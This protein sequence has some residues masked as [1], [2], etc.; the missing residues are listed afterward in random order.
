MAPKPRVLCV[1]DEPQVLEG[2]TLSLRR[3]YEVVTANSGPAGLE[4][5]ARD[6]GVSV[7]VSDMRM[8]GMDGATFLGKARAMAPDATRILLT[9]HADVDGAAAAIN[10]GRIFRFLTKPCSP[11]S[12]V[13]ALDAAVEQHRLVTAE[14]VLLQQTLRGSMQMMMDVLALA[15][16]EAFGRAVRLRRYASEIVS[17]VPGA[18][19]WPVEVAA[20]L[21]E[22][23]IVSL[24]SSTVEKLYEGKPLTSEE[25][26]SVDR[27]PVVI[28]QLIAGIPRLDAVR[29]ALKYQA[30]S[31]EGSGAP[32]TAPRG[33]DIPL[34]ARV[35]RIVADFDRLERG[36]TSESVALDTMRG[37]RGRYDPELLE[38]FAS[39]LGKGTKDVDVLELPIRAVSAGM[40]FLEDVR[41]QA[42][43]LLVA[44][45]HEVTASL[46]ERVR[47]F[48]PGSV[49][50]PV[51]VSARRVARR[52]EGKDPS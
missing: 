23:G 30:V 33:K 40:I 20:M 17:R 50:E 6:E 36:D 14:R 9:G 31:F 43:A 39:I 42:G 1:D 38:L 27:L 35:L 45:G 29:A 8:P 7:I 32:K 25:Q 18:E 10:E 37:R 12:L 19:C 28:E 24:A 51:R 47:N 41:T 13:A 2:V 16:P 26:Q 44:R 49:R 48:V 46:V 3:A 11:A 52:T 4:L 34:G 21:S 5:L 15:A 22:I